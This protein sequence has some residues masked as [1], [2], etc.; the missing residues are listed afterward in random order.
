MRLNFSLC[1]YTGGQNNLYL[2]SLKTTYTDFKEK[3][4]YLFIVLMGHTMVVNI[5]FYFLS[6]ALI[7][8]WLTGDI[9]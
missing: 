2:L 6:L 4:S 9:G 8:Q 1:K 3:L 5:Q 7:Q